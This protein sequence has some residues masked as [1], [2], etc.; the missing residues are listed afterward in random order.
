MT[1]PISVDDFY[2]A[3]PQAPGAAGPMSVD[4][5]YA[6]KK[7]PSA[8]DYGADFP[9]YAKDFGRTVLHGATFG[10]GDELTAGLR[11]LAGGG[12]YA[13]LRE[14][15]RAALKRFADANPKTALAAEIGGGALVPLPGGSLLAGA[16]G[17]A[18]AARAG[19]GVVAAGARMARQGAAAG[20]VSGVGTSEADLTDPSLASATQTAKDAAKGAAVGAA[21]GPLI[22]GAAAAVGTAVN[23]AKGVGGV[24][25]EVVGRFGGRG[26]DEA[27]AHREVADALRQ[28]GINTPAELQAAIAREQAAAPGPVFGVDVGGSRTTRLANDVLPRA[29]GADELARGVQ[30]AQSGLDVGRQA[31]QRIDDQLGLRAPERDAQALN[32][33][34]QNAAG[35]I[36]QG[37]QNDLETRSAEAPELLAL[38]NERPAVQSAWTDAGTAM[39]NKGRALTAEEQA[40]QRT[41]QPAGPPAP[42]QQPGFIPGQPSTTLRP[43][44]PVTENVAVPLEAIDDTVKLLSKRASD[45]D[46]PGSGAISH[47]LLEAHGALGNAIDMAGQ[48]AGVDLAGT[49]QAYRTVMEGRDARL[50]GAKIFNTGGATAREEILNQFRRMDAARQRDFAVGFADELRR[51]VMNT[52]N[53]GFRSENPLGSLENAQLLNQLFHGAHSD[54]VRAL[55]GTLMN[56]GMRNDA[57]VQAAAGRPLQNTAREIGQ[58]AIELG[59]AQVMSPAFAQRQGQRSLINPYTRGRSEAVAQLLMSQQGMQG[60]ERAVASSAGQRMRLDQRRALYDALARGLLRAGVNDATA[61]PATQ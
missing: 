8:A 16:R 40:L 61:N 2:A 60:V 49:R 55:L 38:I 3:K 34:D 4:D 33:A 26:A 54:D 39:A 31:A 41:L 27:F 37:I 20:A 35:R 21:A 9:Q 6:G 57:L 32:T 58:Q 1:G 46:V 15:E 50:A 25:R 36:Y 59:A 23:A 17:A 5:F 10:F 30:Q 53:N 11:H 44:A 18:N 43:P 42:V 7:P 56:R 47:P 13:D 28:A 52:A 45:A 24:I 14:E 29:A 19:E 22:G 48:R 12:S 51:K